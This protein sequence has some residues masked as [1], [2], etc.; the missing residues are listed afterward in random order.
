[1]LSAVSRMSRFL[2]VAALAAGIV[3]VGVSAQG[4]RVRV[5]PPSAPAS[6]PVSA[7]APAPPAEAPGTLGVRVQNLEGTPM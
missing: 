2:A 7:P 5:A 4:T 6:V 3:P 1:M